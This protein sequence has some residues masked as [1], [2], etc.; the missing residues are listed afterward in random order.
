MRRMIWKDAALFFIF[1]SACMLIGTGCS[2]EKPANDA[3]IENI[4]LAEHTKEFKQDI[5]KVTD[6]VYTAIGYGL[7][8]SILLEGKDGTIVVDVL[9]SV[10]AAMPV[11]EAFDKITSKPLK[12]L[13]Y[14]HHHA[15]HVFG[16]SAFAGNKKVDVYSHEKTLEELDRVI[17][18]TQEVTYK[19]A[20]RMFGTFLKIGEM[21]N[22]GIGPFLKFNDRTTM[23][24][25]RPNMT[26]SDDILKVS[27]AGINLELIHAPG[28]TDDQI[29][30]W[31]PDKKVLIAA[32]NYYKSFPNLYTIRG[33]SY[34]DVLAW[35]RSLDKMRSLNAEY[36][37]PCHSRPVYGKD[38]IFTTLTDYRDAIQFVHDQTIRGINKGLTPDELVETVK[39]PRH[40]ADKPYLRE[41]YG[42]VAWS[43]RNIYN[44][45][46][47]WFGG[48]STDLNPLPLKEHAERFAKLAGGKKALIEHAEKAEEE[49]D[50]QWVLELTDVLLALEPDMSKAL[51]LRTASLG[52][53]GLLQGN[54]NARNYYLSQAGES[55]G[56]L[57]L[58]QAKIDKELAHRIPLAAIFNGL[59]VKLNPDK[60]SD[61]DKTAG[62]YFP[63]TK[64]A[65]TVHVRRGVAEIK[66][67][68]PEKADITITVDSNTWKE[69]AAKLSNPAVALAKGD[70]KIKGGII[71]AVNFLG[72]F[73]D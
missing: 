37:V 28:E 68:F 46:L 1:V 64:E 14:T 33:T 31:I 29:V 40:L 53:L 11:K 8:N 43:V 41:Y 42:T 56:K 50:H 27:I 16:A 32:D 58:T 20:M 17:T 48:N 38:K 18:I 69:I 30:I 13:I 12:A 63:D 39:L 71:N 57:K 54:A 21:E 60:S 72:M 66:P 7:A 34:R 65:Y 26:F 19:R 15:D 2:R 61:I 62:F 55:G 44:G 70:V 23:S 49:G 59:S 10:E 6:G 3:G 47:G 24:Y 35:L 51:A 4:E 52:K 36:L 9:E 5:I 67:V 25:I 73:S 22:C 45:Y